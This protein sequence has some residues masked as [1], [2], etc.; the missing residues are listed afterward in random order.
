MRAKT[1][2]G[3]GVTAMKEYEVQMTV[4]GLFRTYIVAKT[5]DEA[6][7]KAMEEAAE[8]DFGRLSDIEWGDTVVAYE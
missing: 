3:A 1:M 6:V 8:A 7:S 2:E 4:E 5:E